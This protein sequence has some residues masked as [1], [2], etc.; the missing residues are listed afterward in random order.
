[1]RYDQNSFAAPADI[2]GAFAL[3]GKICFAKLSHNLTYRK[4][5]WQ[6]WQRAK[7]SAGVAAGPVLPPLWP[8]NVHSAA[9][10]CSIRKTAETVSYFFQ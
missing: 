6:I 1:V 2:T 7:L 9:G 8:K 3:G 10:T 4:S 5:I